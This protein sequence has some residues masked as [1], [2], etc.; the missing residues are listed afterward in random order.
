MIKLF[1]SYLL[2]FILLLTV[3]VA[4]FF[5]YTKR[6][7]EYFKLRTEDAVEQLVEEFQKAYKE[8]PEQ[9]SSVE[10]GI[11]II[12]KN[13]GFEIQFADIN[14]EIIYIYNEVDDS[15]Q[16]PPIDEGV[17]PDPFDREFERVEKSF[18]ITIDG[19]KKGV[20]TIS[21]F[22]EHNLNKNDLQLLNVF[23]RTYRTVLLT[24]I[25]LGIT[26]SFFL[27]RSI[28]KPMK[29]VIQTAN[30]IRNGELLARANVNSNTIE[31][32]ELSY[33]I[34]YL[35]DT[36]Q[37][38]DALRKQM[39]SDMAHE[40]RTPLTALRNF[41]EAFLDGVIEPDSIQLDK[42]YKEVL[43]MADLVERLKDI[44]ALEE[45]Q[46]I[47]HNEQF[48]ICIEIGNMVDLFTPQFVKKE[49]QVQL[50]LQPDLVVFMDKSKLDQMMMNLLSNANRYTDHG[51]TVAI[52][53]IQD[54]K[55]TSI[56]VSDTG[57]GIGREDIPYIF[58]RF[59]R[60]DKSRSRDTGGMGVGLTIVKQLVEL[61]QGQIHV[62]SVVGEG[63]CF[64]I[65][66]E[67]KNINGNYS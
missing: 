30:K 26:V 20:L 56:T 8:D 41:F 61:Y 10:R 11:Q 37:K 43:R 31:I 42:C 66:F 15:R 32:Q 50:D 62:D 60:S 12:T 29:T 9:I 65:E 45:T 40:I 55:T 59:Y 19:V 34:N 1:L 13:M 53:L 24:I 36:L 27:S 35:A 22:G 17:L 58:E 25:I 14:N 52:R 16:P 28:T 6:M 33:A 18:D 21:Y 38:E 54:N 5:G 44:A 63:S 2:I 64:T 4:I 46:L 3:I 49:I 67:N 7:N 47:L 51:G 48:D 39:T 23:Q 57:I